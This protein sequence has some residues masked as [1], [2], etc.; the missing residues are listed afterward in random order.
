MKDPTNITRTQV[1]NQF[2]FNSIKK[3]KDDPLIYYQGIY[4]FLSRQVMII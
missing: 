2:K 1:N 3:I 4:L